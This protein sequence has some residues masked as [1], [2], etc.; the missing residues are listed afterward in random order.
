MRS[1][2]QVNHVNWRELNRRDFMRFS[3]ASAAGLGL[4][5]LDPMAWA[6]TREGEMI[7]RTLG[8]TG[9]KVSAIGLG[10][11][12]IGQASSEE[13]CTRII[14]AAVDRGITF[15]DNCWDYNGGRSEEWMGKSLEGGYRD[16]VFLMSKIDGQTKEAASRQIDES[17]KRL[18]TD[19]LDL[20]QQHEMIRPED[21]ERIFA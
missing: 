4:L 6:Q 8:R 9:E 15:M 14:H 13:E 20:L 5:Q 3:A 7:Y 12:H 2:A 17:L 19:H 1:G 21:P 11:A 16:K 10:G 18:R